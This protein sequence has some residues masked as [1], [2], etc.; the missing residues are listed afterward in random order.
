MWN[1]LYEMCLASENFLQF[2][3]GIFSYYVVWCTW[4]TQRA[5]YY[6]KINNA[7]GQHDNILLPTN[8]REIPMVIETHMPI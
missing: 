3:N 2:D 1:I 7:I 5:Q 6:L 8:A 4:F